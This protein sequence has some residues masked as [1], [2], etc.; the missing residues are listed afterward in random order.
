MMPPPPSVSEDLPVTDLP[1]G[2]RNPIGVALGLLGDE[3]TLL[4]LRHALQGTRLYGEWMRELPISNAVLTGRLGRLTES[5]LLDRVAYQRKPERFEYRL[6][7]RGRTAWPIL[8]G[9]WSWE[10][11]WV[12]QHAETLPR[13]RHQVCGHLFSPVLVC[14]ACDAPA[15]PRDLVGGFGPSGTWERS[16][17]SATTRRR[18]ADAH[19]AGFFPQTTALVGNRW[20]CALLGAAFQGTRR[21]S[22]FERQLSAPPVVIADRLRTFTELGVMTADYRLT[23]KGLAFFPVVVHTMEWAQTWFR[24]P[25][26]PAMSYRHRPCGTAFH[27]R[28]ACSEC[29]VPLRAGTIDRVPA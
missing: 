19:Q 15:G 17:P 3:W 27:P 9:I 11:S 1:A 16:M 20:S 4:I 6:T 12:G 26:G 28:Y 25:E 13:M 24:S 14:G 23:A 2:G 29:A 21:F 10:L 22:D 18:S 7:R 8:L 5:G